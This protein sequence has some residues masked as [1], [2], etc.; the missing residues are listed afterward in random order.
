MNKEAQELADPPVEISDF[1]AT[2][3]RQNE[4]EV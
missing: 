4:K 1:L 3:C 2:H